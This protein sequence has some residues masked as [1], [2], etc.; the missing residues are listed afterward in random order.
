M[1]THT[2]VTVQQPQA[3]TGNNPCVNLLYGGRRDTIVPLYRASIEGTWEVAKD[4]LQGDGELVKYRITEN[5]ETPLHVAAAAGHSTK[6]VGNLVKMMNDED[7]FK[8]QNR[9]GNTAFCLAAISGN[10]SMAKI[11]IEKKKLELRLICGRD[12]MKPLYLAAFHGNH[13]MVTYLYDLFI[14]NREMGTLDWTNDDMDNVLLK[15]F[16]LHE[17][18]DVALRIL[19]KNKE[20]PQDKHAWNVLQVLARNPA[21]FHVRSWPIIRQITSTLALIGLVTRPESKATTLL[22]LLWGRIIKR[23]KDVIDKILRGPMVVENNMET[24]P[25]Q[26]LFIAA[27]INNTRFLV[28]LIREYPDLIRKR[29]DDGQ[30]IFH[31]SVSHRHHNI[32]SLLYE[33]GSIKDLITPI[34]DH[35]GNNILHLVG[36]NPEKNAYED[37]VAAP[38]QIQSEFLWYKREVRNAE[39]KTPEELFKESHKDLVI[40]GMQWINET[41]NQSM[42]VAALVCTI[43]F[44]VVFSIPGGYDQNNGLPI[45]LQ[46]RHFIAFIVMDAISFILSTSSILTFLSIVLSRHQRNTE[47]MLQK[48]VIGH[49]ALLTSILAIVVAFGISFF[50]L[51]R[52]AY[53]S[54][55]PFIVYPSVIILV[56][57]YV[58]VYFSLYTDAIKAIYSRRYLFRAKHMLYRKI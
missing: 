52:S 54:T 8:L 4:I 41:I 31:I 58:P 18:L 30:T 28:E 1:A 20:L 7:D 12:N 16:L 17:L 11:M 15:C 26:I 6:F 46:D 10:V 35:Q 5:N 37:W 51:Y 23:P 47:L 40:R 3:S 44:T 43:G 53:K 9:D 22:K 29:N 49:L 45:L 42:V 38:F 2:T 50:I 32:Y 36:Q 56:C 34:T 21:A 57:L 55:V 24:Y 25:S 14:S 48:W 13:D 27:E 33:I 39:G 19:E